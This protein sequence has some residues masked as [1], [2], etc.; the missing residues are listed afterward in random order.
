MPM[1]GVLGVALLTTIGEVPVTEVTVPEPE[2]PAVAQAAP[3]QIF[4]VDV[5]V[6]YQNSPREL[7]V[8]PAGV[9]LGA[10]ALT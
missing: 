5:L 2:D 4:R 6:S 3:V 10:V 7:P 8:E 9:A 1:I